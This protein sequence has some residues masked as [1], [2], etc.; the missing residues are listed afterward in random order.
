MKTQESEIDID[1]DLANSIVQHIINSALADGSLNPTGKSK[2]QFNQEVFSYLRKI[3]ESDAQ[4]SLILDHRKTLLDQ[5]RSF[6]KSKNVELAILFYATWTEHMLNL[7]VASYLRRRKLADSFIQDF[8]RDTGTKSKYIF[9][10]SSY[11][12]KNPA[13]S[14]I[15]K[16][17][18]ISERRNQFVHFKWKGYDDLKSAQMKREYEK[19]LEWAESLVRHF[20]LLEKKYLT[21]AK[22]YTLP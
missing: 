9:I 19:G 14:W 12:E 3:A 6:R 17:N 16:L 1:D 5:A 11:T 7:F 22:I 13:K 8:L 10:I 21:Y 4:F 20:N 2:D 18:F 15:T